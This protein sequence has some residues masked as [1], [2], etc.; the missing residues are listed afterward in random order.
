MTVEDARIKFKLRTKMLN[1]KFNYKN[2]PAY[3]AALWLCHSC[4]SSIETQSHILWCPAYAELR[5]GKD[6]NSDKD[7]IEYI[8][9][10]LEFRDKLKI[11]K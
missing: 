10:V 2:E 3:R 7:L 5:E 6:I 9:N 4:Q 11:T 8:K 1:T